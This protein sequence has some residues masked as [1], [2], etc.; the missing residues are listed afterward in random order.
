MPPKDAEGR[1]REGGPSVI[2]FIVF[3]GLIVVVVAVALIFMGGQVSQTFGGIGES[4]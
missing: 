3:I 4:V 1:A 2:Q